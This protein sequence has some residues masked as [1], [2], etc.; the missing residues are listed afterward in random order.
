MSSTSSC[1]SPSSSGRARSACDT[2]AIHSFAFAIGFNGASTLLFSPPGAH[3][4]SSLRFFCSVCVSS[5]C[6]MLGSATV[7][8]PE[9]AVL[10]N[11]LA[12]K[13]HFF[14]S[15]AEGFGW[16]NKAPQI[17]RR[18]SRW[19]GADFPHMLSASPFFFPS[20]AASFASVSG[21]SLAVTEDRPCCQLHTSIFL[22]VGT[23]RFVTQSPTV[24]VF[25]KPCNVFRLWVRSVTDGGIA[26][27]RL[28]YLLTWL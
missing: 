13:S 23:E 10:W 25:P 6:A 20:R 18:C 12:A 9:C 11:I 3:L 28:A 17:S 5:T 27:R 2:A 7:A 15:A 19:C 24:R 1:S 21:K 16:V 26:V 22:V 8:H 14:C 4:L